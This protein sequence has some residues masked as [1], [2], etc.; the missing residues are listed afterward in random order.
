MPKEI[1]Y[2]AIP[3]FDETKH[4][5]EQVEPVDMGEYMFVDVVIKNLDLTEIPVEPTAPVSEPY[6]SEKTDIEILQDNQ[7]Q[8]IQNLN[9]FMDYVFS[10]VPNL[11]Q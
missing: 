3:A 6:V 2:A 7:K 10:N 8:V 1:R 9:D 11:P 4:Y 5:V